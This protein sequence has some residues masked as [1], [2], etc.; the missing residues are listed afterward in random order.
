MFFILTSILF[1]PIFAQYYEVTI[2]PTGNWQL[3]VLQ[4]SIT[5]LE[6]GDEL[7]VFDANGVVDDQGNTVRF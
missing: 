3:I 5:G 7:G 6:S 1:A 2:D 4:D